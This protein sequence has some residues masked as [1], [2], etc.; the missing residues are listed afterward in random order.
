MDI[1]AFII[2]IVAGGAWLLVLAVLIYVSVTEPRR[3]K[4]AEQDASLKDD[5]FWH[6]RL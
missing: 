2:A 6:T 3:R 4:R 5:P 1:L